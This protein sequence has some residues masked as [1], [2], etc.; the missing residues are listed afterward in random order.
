M[1]HADSQHLSI[2]QYHKF[3]DVVALS[4]KMKALTEK[5]KKF[6]LLNMPLLIQGET[7]TGKDLIAKACHHFG[8]RKKQKFIAVNCAGLP[9]E[10]AESEMFGRAGSKKSAIGFFEYADGGTV[11][12][13]GVAELPLILQAKLLR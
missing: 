1:I 3:D 7:G 2:N 10:D 13:D 8:H 9:G 4:P 12:L 11:L 5:A 6:A